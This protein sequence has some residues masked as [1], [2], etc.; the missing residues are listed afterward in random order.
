[1]G[2]SV[3]ITTPIPTLDEIG[4][5]LKMSKAR[6]RRLIEIVTSS[7]PVQFAMRH[8]DLSDSVNGREHNRNGNAKL[9]MQ[10]SAA[11]GSVLNK[12][13]KHAAAG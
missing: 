7:A 12:K 1:M 11:K 4:K 6:Q 10:R 3:Y 13:S 9:S 5:R 8:R 2:R